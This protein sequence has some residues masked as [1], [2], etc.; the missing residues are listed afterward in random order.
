MKYP[1][2]RLLVFC[3]APLPGE[4]KTR[5]ARSIGAGTACEVHQQL[6]QHTL[7]TVTRH[8]LAPVQ[9][10]CAPNCAHDFFSQCQQQ[11]AVELREQGEGDLGARMARAFA[12]TLHSASFAVIIGTDCPALN[13]DYL[14]QAFAALEQGQDAV[15]GPAEDG[16]YVLLGLRQPQ[17]AI[18][19]DIEWGSAEVLQQTLQRLR[20][21]VH[22]LPTLWDVDQIDDLRRLRDS[23]DALGLDAEFQTRLAALMLPQN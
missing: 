3:K 16:G 6:A 4:V 9:L 10:W 19:E 23:A 1:Q 17:P 2:G 14:A 20:G 22:C 12:D 18:F 21:S 13:Q 5:L 8:A 15:I 7:Q 11:Y